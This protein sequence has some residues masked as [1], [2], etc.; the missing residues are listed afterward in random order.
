MTG[1]C[2]NQ[3]TNTDL[4]VKL[5]PRNGIHSVNL[6]KRLADFGVFSAS[7]LTL[8]C[9]IVITSLA[10]E[11]SMGYILKQTLPGSEINGS[12]EVDWRANDKLPSMAKVIF[13]FWNYQGRSHIGYSLWSICSGRF[14]VMVTTIDYSWARLQSTGRGI[15]RTSAFPAISL[16]LPVFELIRRPILTIILP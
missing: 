12:W 11:N 5:C 14:L 9:A 16:F 13:S 8:A 7:V 10:H 2:T 15:S 6:A 1:A 3:Y 4:I